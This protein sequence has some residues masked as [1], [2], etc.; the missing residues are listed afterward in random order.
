M[1]ELTLILSSILGFCMMFYA[2]VAYIRP[3]TRL[4]Q[5]AKAR[6]VLLVMAHPD[7]ETMFFGPTI[8]NLSRQ[9]ETKVFLLCLST[10]DYRNKG[11]IRKRELY[12]ACGILGIPEERICVLRS[13]GEPEFWS[14]ITF[15]VQRRE[16]IGSYTLIL[17]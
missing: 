9:E 12:D 10:G 17:I 5:I 6:R 11:L 16:I 3:Y 8:L 4:K 15:P 2:L 1:E 14:S 13:V 7:D